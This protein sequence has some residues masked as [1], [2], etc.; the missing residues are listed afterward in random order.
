MS[1]IG[2]MPIPI[3]GGVQASVEGSVF[4]VKGPKG[5]LS[6]ELHP[7]I[8]VKVDD[9]SIVCERNSE[10]KAHRSLHGLVRSLVSNMVT[11]VSNGY[12]IR[13]EVQGVGY[14]AELQ[15]KNLNLS[16]GYAHPLFIEPKEGISF[17]VG[18][19]TNTRMPFLILRGIDKETIGQQAAEIRRMK[20]PEPY[21]GKGIRYAGEKIRR[22][23]G[24]SGKA[25]G[26]K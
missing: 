23:A 19:D 4:T 7:D 6:R 1:R 5:T 13:M 25:A 8:A 18:M 22:K 14:R 2:K 21:K 24:K 9:G 16:V 12:E 3:P 10:D 15:G 11:G 17:E 26:K 20:P